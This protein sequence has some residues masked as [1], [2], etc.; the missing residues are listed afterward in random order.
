MKRISIIICSLLLL[1]LTLIWVTYIVRKNRIE[2]QYVSKSS[3]GI[4]SIAVDDLL[5]DNVSQ[6]LNFDTHSTGLEGGENWIKKIVW[7]A[8]ISIPARVFLFN[9]AQQKSQFYGIL[10]ISNYDDCFSFFANQYPEAINF[11]DKKQGIVRVDVNKQIKVLFDR[12]HLVYKLGFDHN[13]DF[14]ELQSLLKNQDS[15]VQVGSFKGF[16]HAL[17]KKHI[18]Y[19]LK[20]SSLIV[21]AIVKKHRTDISGKW[22][23]SDNIDQ[24]LEVRKMDTTNQIVTF[25]SLLPLHDVP[26]LSQLISKYTGLD[27]EQLKKNY[28]NYLDLQIKTDSIIQ[29]DSSIAYT[30]DDDFN[31]IEEIEIK[32]MAVPYIIHTW[33]YNAALAASLP[34]KMFYQFHKTHID[35]YLLNTTSELPPD[36]TQNERTQH[37]FYCF[38][39]F[40]AWPEKWTISPF[41]RLKDN[42]VRAKLTTTFL[43]KNILA[44]KGEITY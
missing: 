17:T 2:N 9:T 32:E 30:Y 15:W 13:S 35:T 14:N 33:K 24:N 6:L 21:E 18:G 42:K 28:A 44:I 4:L 5:L 19:V 10:A 27:Q 20:D 31:A 39:D 37:P 34:A 23:L 25:W 8:G 40:K 43:D 16:E 1:F 11:V 41:S 22:F 38:I 36:R 7:N 3:T 29:K 26:V 12:K